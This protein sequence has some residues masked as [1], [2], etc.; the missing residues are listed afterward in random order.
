MQWLNITDTYCKEIPIGQFYA[1]KYTEAVLL[2]VLKMVFT[3]FTL[4][5]YLF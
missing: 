1:E 5:I 2:Y 4:N 3:A